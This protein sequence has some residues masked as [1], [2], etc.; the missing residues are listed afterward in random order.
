MLS[1]YNKIWYNA[2][3]EYDVWHDVLETMDGYQ[4][5]DD[6]P[7]ILEDTSSNYESPNEYIQ[8]EF[9]IGDCQT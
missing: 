3:E 7:T 6:P 5:W 2:H 9:Y 8:P 1:V 4:E